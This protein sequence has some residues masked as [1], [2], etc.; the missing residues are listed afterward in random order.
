[1]A[2]TFRIARS[3]TVTAK[4]YRRSQYASTGPAT[5]APQISTPAF[6]GD[7]GDSSMQAQP[8]C[9]ILQLPLV[10]INHGCDPDLCH[11]D[12]GVSDER[13]R[14]DS[15]D[16][17]PDTRSSRL[18]D[19]PPVMHLQHMGHFVAQDKGELRFILE[20]AEQTR[21]DQKRSIG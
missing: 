16:G 11:E 8:V 1:M 13:T 7:I 5:L 17:Q 6:L 18:F 21:I 20:R 2:D 15:R 9:L 14:C 4:P 12:S 19:F 3:T 10:T